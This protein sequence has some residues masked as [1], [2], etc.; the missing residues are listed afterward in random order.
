MLWELVTDADAP[1]SAPLRS[2]SELR[3]RPIGEEPAVVRGIHLSTARS[4]LVALR[5][6]LARQHRYVLADTPVFA[7]LSASKLL[8]LCRR[9]KLV[10]VPAGSIVLA[11]DSAALLGNYRGI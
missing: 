10:D 9:G 4:R 5:E 6:S 8:T 3:T 11:A 2:W 7:P 1:L